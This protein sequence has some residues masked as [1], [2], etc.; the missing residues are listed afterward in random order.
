MRTIWRAITDDEIGLLP[1]L[2]SVL[3]LVRA[4]VLERIHDSLR[5]LFSCDVTLDLYDTWYRRLWL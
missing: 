3:L 4:V 2:D 5:R 1:L